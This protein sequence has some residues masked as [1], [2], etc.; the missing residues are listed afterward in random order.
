MKK[1]R[2]VFTPGFGYSHQVWSKL[3]QKWLHVKF[4]KG[5]TK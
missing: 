4:T 1:T 3:E 2:I 5:K